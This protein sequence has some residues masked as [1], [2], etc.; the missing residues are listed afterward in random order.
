M[1]SKTVLQDYMPHVLRPSAI[2]PALHMLCDLYGGTFW[3]MHGII[4]ASLSSLVRVW[5][6]T[7]NEVVFP[8]KWDN[9]GQA[10]ETQSM[11]D[12]RLT[13]SSL[14]GESDSNHLHSVCSVLWMT[15]IDMLLSQ[16]LIHITCFWY[17]AVVFFNWSLN[18]LLQPNYLWELLQLGIQLVLLFFTLLLQLGFQLFLLFFT[19]L[20]QLG[21]LVTLLL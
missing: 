7:T 14:L 16:S 20:L 5:S 11:W 15:I 8:G 17:K 9:S 6:L 3:V 13:N 10:L 4:T 19:L 18:V 12:T 2:R 21:Q 1:H